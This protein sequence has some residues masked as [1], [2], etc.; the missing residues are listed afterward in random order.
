MA[1]YLTVTCR[2]PASAEE[3]LAQALE[4]WPVLGCQVEDAGGEVDVTVFLDERRAVD[5]PRVCEG[6]RALGA[7]ELDTGR[8]AEQDWL[9]GYRHTLAAR[10]VGTRFWVDPH[11]QQ[12]TAAPDGRVHLVVEPRQAFGSGSH[13]STQ[14]VM[15]L[16]EEIDVTGRRVLDVGTGSGILA[17]AARGLGAAWVAGFDIDLEA[18]FVARQTVAEQPRQ[19]EVALFAGSTAAL[20]GDPRFDLILANLLPVQVEP[21]LGFLR[22][23]VST[24]GELLVSGLMVDQRAAVEAELTAAGFEVVAAHELGEWAGLICKAVARGPRPVTRQGKGKTQHPTLQ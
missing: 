16:L 22:S 13:E 11:P 20:R 14:L 10:A 7:S 5:V 24:G 9:S 1:D 17:L 4:R 12:P 8:F 19:L 23:L 21:L 2:L 15:L 18:M 3:H 6:L